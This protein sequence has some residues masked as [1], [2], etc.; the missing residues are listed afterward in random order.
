MTTL[1][2]D[3]ADAVSRQIGRGPRG[4]LAEGLRALFQTL[5]I[6]DHRI[7]LLDAL[8]ER[9]MI[10]VVWEAGDVQEVRPDLTDEQAWEVLRAARQ[11]H[12][13]GL[14]INWDVLECHA[15]MLFPEPAEDRP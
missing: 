5:G 8:A 6:E 7:E 3:L 13:A 11:E 14:G 15:D 10:A 4:K 2:I 12:D 9:R 1:T